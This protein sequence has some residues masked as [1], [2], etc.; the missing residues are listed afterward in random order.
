MKE[1]LDMKRIKEWKL[2]NKAAILKPVRNL[3]SQSS[4]IWVA[5]TYR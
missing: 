3:F 1:G 2:W 4:S 5:W